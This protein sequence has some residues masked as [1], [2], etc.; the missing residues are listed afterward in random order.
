MNIIMKIGGVGTKMNANGIL[1]LD[2]FLQI[3]DVWTYWQSD[4]SIPYTKG[5]PYGIF[6]KQVIIDMKQNGQLN[7]I[8][9]QL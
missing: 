2:I 1:I 3:E 5:L 9:R 7:K 4:L 6:M 8:K